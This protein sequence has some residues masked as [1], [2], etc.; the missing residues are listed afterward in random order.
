MHCS[1]CGKEL[2]DTSAFCPICGT[3][4]SSKPEAHTNK[5]KKS[6]FK[7][8]IPVIAVILILGALPFVLP[9]LIPTGSSK[10]SDD[11]S[12]VSNDDLMENLEEAYTAVETDNSAVSYD[13]LM[14]NLEEAYTAVETA[15]TQFSN[16]ESEDPSKVMKQRV[17]IMSELQQTLDD[18]QTQSASLTGD[19]DKLQE[20][21]L[22]YYSMAS[23]FAKVYL[24]YNSFF[25]RFIGNDSFVQGRPNLFDSN[26]T[27]QE[28]YEAMN[29]WYKSSKTQYTNFEYPSFV[30]AYWKEYENILDLNQAV[31]GKYASAIKL[32][33]HLRYRSCQELFNRCQVVED[34]WF[35][36]TRK[37][38]NNIAKGYGDSSYLGFVNL[39]TEIQDYINISEKEKEKYVFSNN[40]LNELFYGVKC[41]DTIYPSL[42]N[43]YD[44]FVIINLAAY[45][46]Q[47]KIDIEVEI[48]GFTQKYRQSYTVTSTAKTL[49]IKP[50]L[51]TGDLDLSSAKS[52]QINITIYEKDGTQISTKSKPVTIKSKNDVEWFSNDF[53]VFTKDNI[54]CFLT[55]ES[56]SI[57]SLKRSAIDEVTKMTGGKMENLAGYQEGRIKSHYTITYLQ[58]A[59]LMRAMYN[60]GVRYTMDGFSVSGSNQHVLLP[61]QV[62]E[63]RSGLCIE[64]SLVIASALQS[65][66]MHAF[67]IFP[68]GHAQVAV[69]VWNSGKGSGEYFLIETT[70]LN[71]NSIN[72]TAFVDFANAL[73]KGELD[74]KNS[75]CIQ[76]KNKDEWKEYLKKVEYVIDCNDSRI[77]GMTPFSN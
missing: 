16:I 20:A 50:P 62:L 64:T 8:V 48:P 27:P 29:N 54:L 42:Y 21:V 77:L 59:A 41:V 23:S 60:T 2:N 19:D 45:G 5:K 71:N 53:G 17:T 1:K 49:F 39:Y 56:S 4:C 24:D 52:A 40:K 75:S 28:N 73:Q 34:K 51:L 13:D 43:T 32:N 25:V 46:G 12:A 22:S 76:Y 65:A 74:A 7:I 61:E 33:D 14:E 30:E 18:L 67:L 15:R 70:A 47:K 3:P 44:S 10:T 55:P 72:G 35:D 36:D 57:A 26:K 68:P 6:V 63:L 58:A 37:S 31:M 11:N 66:K 38:C 69:E 9:K